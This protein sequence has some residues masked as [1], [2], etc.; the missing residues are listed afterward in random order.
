[1]KF[2]FVVGWRSTH[3]IE[4]TINAQRFRHGKSASMKFAGTPK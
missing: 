1:M 2:K 3:S 4:F